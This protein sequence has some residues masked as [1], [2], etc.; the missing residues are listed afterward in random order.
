MAQ[1]TGCDY[2]YRFDSFEE[3]AAR[4]H[5][6]FAHTGHE[7]FGAHRWLDQF[8]QT[9]H[10]WVICSQ[11]LANSCNEPDD[12]STA[13]LAAQLLHAKVLGSWLDLADENRAAV[14]DVRRQFCG[15]LTLAL[16]LLD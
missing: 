4:V 5:A 2:H 6:L 11:A 14:V 16:C 3:F 10:V 12:S 1:T 9:D 7:D 13:L 15:M 8:R